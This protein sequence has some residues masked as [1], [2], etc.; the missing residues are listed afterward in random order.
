MFGRLVLGHVSWTDVSPS[1]RSPCDFMISSR[2]SNLTSSCFV[3]SVTIG[4][5][6]ESFDVN[7]ATVQVGLR[8][9]YGRGK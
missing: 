4:G 7:Y 8:Y 6:P 5:I 3:Q 9:Q 2:V 1:P